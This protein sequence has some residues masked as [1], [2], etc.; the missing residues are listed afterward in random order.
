MSDN[1]KEKKRLQKEWENAAKSRD[2]L[3]MR[4]VQEKMNAL[5]MKE[6]RPDA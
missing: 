6:Q 4:Q 1:E 2:T 5:L 3:T